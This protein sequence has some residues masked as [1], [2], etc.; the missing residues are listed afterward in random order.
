[1]KIPALVAHLHLFHKYKAQHVSF[2]KLIKQVMF[3]PGSLSTFFAGKF[4]AVSKIIITPSLSVSLFNCCC[5]LHHTSPC[6]YVLLTGVSFQ[7]VFT[8]V[9][10]KGADHLRPA[11]QCFQHQT[12]GFQG[13][14]PVYISAL[15]LHIVALP[16][17]CVH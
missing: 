1:M 5:Q 2:P 12:K 8:R 3:S 14:L 11:G 9:L 4:V 16:C 6:S 13:N 7:T 17:I 10:I 15:Q